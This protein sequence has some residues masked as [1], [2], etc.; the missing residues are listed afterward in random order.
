MQRP[1]GIPTPIKALLR[2]WYHRTVHSIAAR[3]ERKYIG[4]IAGGRSP[5]RLLPVS[6]ELAQTL[7]EDLAVPSDRMEVIPNPLDLNRFRPG[8]EPLLR[9]EIC[10]AANWHPA[11]F[12]MLFVGGSWKRKGLE[13]VLATLPRLPGPVKLLVVGAG[14]VPAYRQ[15][16]R[17]RGVADRVWFAGVR[18]DVERFYR[19]AGA[20]I[21]PSS[22][23]ALPLSCTEALASSLPVVVYSFPGS[24]TLVNSGVN[25]FIVDSP[26]GI[27]SAIE[28]LRADPALHANMSGAARSSVQRFAPP[29]IADRLM[30][31]FEGKRRGKSAPPGTRQ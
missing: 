10:A 7:R 27:A 19:I 18:S 21:L 16:A 17:N 13:A 8:D 31:V 5:T 22:F 25:G 11:S 9:E 20:A 12:I 23:E 30:H 2:S 6:D 28:T 26:E 1:Q 24:A 3:H 4:A 14:D 29:A 15:I